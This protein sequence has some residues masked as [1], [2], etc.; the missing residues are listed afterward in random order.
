[1]SDQERDMEEQVL[2]AA[3]RDMMEARSDFWSTTGNCAGIT[4]FQDE[5]S[6]FHERICL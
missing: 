2:S 6:V 3:D 5:I 4:S 1:M